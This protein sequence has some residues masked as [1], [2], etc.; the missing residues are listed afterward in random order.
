MEHARETVNRGLRHCGGAI[1]GHQVYSIS[2]SYTL[3]SDTS[4]TADLIHG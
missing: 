1:R 4:V 2:L 3:L